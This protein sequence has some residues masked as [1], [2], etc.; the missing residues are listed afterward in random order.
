MGLYW[1][2]HGGTMVQF[3]LDHQSTCSLQ[4]FVAVAHLKRGSHP[5]FLSFFLSS[6]LSVFLRF[7][8]SSSSSMND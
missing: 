7:A 2:V 8:C 3:L 4:L 6:F 5:G 1:H